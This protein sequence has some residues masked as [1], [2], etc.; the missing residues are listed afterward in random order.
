[1]FWLLLLS[2]ELARKIRYPEEET[3]YITYSKI[4][5]L[6]NAIIILYVIQL[7]TVLIAV[8]FY[9]VLELSNIYLITLIIALFYITHCYIKFSHRKYSSGI[10]LKIS[11]EIFAS[12]NM[13][14]IIIECF[15]NRG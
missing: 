6:Q 7:I 2:W 14:I 1:M 15:L 9:L 8:Y 11:A 5:G 10:Q 13:V 3:A 12:V 4:F